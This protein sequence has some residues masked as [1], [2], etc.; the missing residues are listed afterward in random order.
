MSESYRHESTVASDNVLKDCRSSFYQSTLVFN[1]FP[2]N[3][4]RDMV[5]TI[6]KHLDFRLAKTSDVDFFHQNNMTRQAI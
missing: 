6:T 4:R 2:N 1:S 5:A 3:S